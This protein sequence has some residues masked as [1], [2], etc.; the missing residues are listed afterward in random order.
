MDT[1]P[2]FW[3]IINWWGGSHWRGARLWGDRFAEAT[4]KSKEVAKR[5]TT[6]KQPAMRG[7]R[8]VFSR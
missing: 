1:G 7:W 6:W 5:W 3:I 8:Q 4:R 2:A